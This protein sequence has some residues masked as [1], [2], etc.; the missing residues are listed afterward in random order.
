MG[1]FKTTMSFSIHLRWGIFFLIWIIF[2]SGIFSNWIDSPGILQAFQAKV[3][4]SHQRQAYAKAK[5]RAQKLSKQARHLKTNPFAQ[6][7]E[8]RSVLG[9]VQDDELVFDFNGAYQLGT[10]DKK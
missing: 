4:L 10:T 5:E 7:R 9:Y 8:V 1:N 2:L 6:E 3:L